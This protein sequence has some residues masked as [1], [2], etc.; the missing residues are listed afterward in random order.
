MF[1]GS[2]GSRPSLLLL[3][4]L[5]MSQPTSLVTVTVSRT[6][7]G[8]VLQPRLLWTKT[9]LLP[10]AGLLPTW[11]APSCPWLESIPTCGVKP[12]VLGLQRFPLFASE[13]LRTP[14]SILS[15]AIQVFY[16]PFKEFAK[17]NKPLYDFALSSMGSSLAAAHFSLHAAAFIEE[18]LQRLPTVLQGPYWAKWCGDVAQAF[19]ADV[20]LPLRDSTC[21]FPVPLEAQSWL[22]G[23]ALSR[24]R[25]W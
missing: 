9:S 18:F 15:G 2:L 20:L 21:A 7:L 3:T 14:A 16:A 10:P 11:P 24:V 5:R 23:L 6:V 22:L 19:Q 25:R 17:D 12:S 4:L 1:Q 13:P 8:M